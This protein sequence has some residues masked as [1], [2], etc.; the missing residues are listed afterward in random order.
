MD[1]VCSVLKKYIKFMTFL[2]T[3]YDNGRAMNAWREI[4][5]SVHSP[6]DS[7]FLLLAAG[8]AEGFAGFLVGVASVGRVPAG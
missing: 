6:S 2:R 1:P 7:L 4:P 8:A 3:I 5:L